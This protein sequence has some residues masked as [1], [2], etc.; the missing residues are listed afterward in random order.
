MLFNIVLPT[1]IPLLWQESAWNAYFVC[2][3]LRYAVGLNI[4]WTVNSVAHIWGNRPYDKNINP[5]ENMFVS[6][7][8]M[9]EGYHNYHHTFPYDYRASEFSLKMNPTAIFIDFFA[10]IGWAYEKKTVSK[11]A[12]YRKMQRSGEKA[13][14]KNN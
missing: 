12:I 14:Q 9:G 5:A 10:W 11:E 3:A 13:D 6:I 1:S 8:T 7:G 4:T 2:F